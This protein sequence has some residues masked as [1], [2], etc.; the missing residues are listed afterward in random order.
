MARE[1]IR[2]VPNLVEQDDLVNAGVIG[3]M[4]A[5]DRFESRGLKFWTFASHRVRGAMLD[6]LRGMD[7]AA[8]STRL[9]QKKSDAFYWD[10]QRKFGRSPT[11]QEI[12]GH[13]KMPEERWLKWKVRMLYT[14]EVSLHNKYA[15]GDAQAI[16]FK[17]TARSPYDLARGAELREHLESALK[18][19]PPRYRRVLVQYFYKD[20]KLAKTGKMLKVVESRASQIKTAALARLRIEL[21]SRGISFGAV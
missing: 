10:F 14:S 1:M 2:K 18:T 5:A 19:L 8:R 6:L 7:G 4:D 16:E 3:L 12:A 15:N 21:E 17:C 9:I 20:Q 13:L 11:D